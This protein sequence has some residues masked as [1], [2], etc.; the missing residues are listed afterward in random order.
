MILEDPK[1][2][3]RNDK[4]DNKVITVLLGNDTPSE[5]KSWRCNVC[6]KVVFHYYSDVR[7]VIE[8]EMREVKRPLDIM[9]IKECKTIY[10]I[11]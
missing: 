2:I 6:G 7:I 11:I 1:I 3:R 9:C 10:R 4:N 8:G 5:R